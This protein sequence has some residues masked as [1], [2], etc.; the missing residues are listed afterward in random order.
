MRHFECPDNF[1]G[2]YREVN[3]KNMQISYVY[4][5]KCSDNT[6]YTGVTENVYNRYEEHQVGKHF[7]SYTFNRRPFSLE[8]FCSFTNIEIA[9]EFEKNFKK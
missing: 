6:Y 3:G 7:G 8:Y 4:I 1:V 5:L 2:M 9:I